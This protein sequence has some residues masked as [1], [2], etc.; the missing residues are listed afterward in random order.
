MGLPMRVGLDTGRSTLT[1]AGDRCGGRGWGPPSASV[2]GSPPSV[3]PSEIS[4]A[5]PDSISH[6]ALCRRYDL[7]CRCSSVT[8]F[9]PEARS[10]HPLLQVGH[11]CLLR[12]TSMKDIVKGSF[13][14]GVPR[15]PFFSSLTVLGFDS[16]VTGSVEKRSD[17]I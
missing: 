13:M 12:S 9:A 3:V 16:V 4:P 17:W 10:G 1:E 14:V 11:R 6:A 7:L 5:P 2:L 8:Q 15:L